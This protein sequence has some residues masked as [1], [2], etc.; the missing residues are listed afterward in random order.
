MSRGV[1]LA[2]NYGFVGRRGTTLP[3]FRPCKFEINYVAMGFTEDLNFA[4]HLIG[5]CVQMQS[6]TSSDR[7]C[8]VQESIMFL[9]TSF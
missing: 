6:D 9:Q 7:H 4:D 5:K 1:P 2:L 3:F 8:E